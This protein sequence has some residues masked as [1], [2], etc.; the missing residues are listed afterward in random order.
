MK[1]FATI[2]GVFLTA[3]IMAGV[4]GPAWATL[5]AYDGFGTSGDL[6]G[7]TGSANSMGFSAAWTTTSTETGKMYYL[8]EPSLPL[9]SNNL[10]FE[11]GRAVVNTTTGNVKATRPL[12]TTLGADSGKTWY[13]SAELKTN[14]SGNCWELFGIANNTNLDRRVVSGFTWVGGYPTPG[15]IDFLLRIVDGTGTQQ[16]ALKGWSLGFGTPAFYVVKIVTYSDGKNDAYA[17]LYYNTDT[18]PAVEPTN[19]DLSLSVTGLSGVTYSYA[20]L[21]GRGATNYGQPG[22]EADEFRIGTTWQDVV[23]IPEP[24][25]LALL[26]CGLIGLLC[27]AWRRRK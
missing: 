12:S 14:T 18:L 9:P 8:T 1:S 13:F 20:F 16:Q 4:S 25:T 26:A 27:Y 10:G 17:K 3:V 24:S 11:G 5:L 2:L 6:N 23:A 7:S 22:C 15:Y 21:Q 19:W